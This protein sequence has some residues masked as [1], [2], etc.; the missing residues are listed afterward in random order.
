MPYT[1]NRKVKKLDSYN[2]THAKSGAVTVTRAD[3]SK[4]VIQQDIKQTR[5]AKAKRATVKRK[6]E[7]VVKVAYRISEQS[8]RATSNLERDLEAMRKMGTIHQED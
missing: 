7:R 1:R 4:Y 3:G 5:K 8:T 6:V 2:Q